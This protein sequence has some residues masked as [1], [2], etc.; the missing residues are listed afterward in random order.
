[1]HLGHGSSASRHHIGPAHIPARTI[2]ACTEFVYSQGSTI[3]KVVE[4]PAPMP[5]ENQAEGC[6]TQS[7]EGSSGGEKCLFEEPRCGHDVIP[8]RAN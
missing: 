3:L 4:L 2:L 7:R 1:M 8:K 5:L 6:P